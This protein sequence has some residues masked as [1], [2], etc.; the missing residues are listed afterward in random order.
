MFARSI[1]LA[2][3]AGSLAFATPALAQ[4]N[5]ETTTTTVSRSSD[6]ARF[7]PQPTGISTTIDY[8]FL[9]EALQYMV[10][11][12]GP[13]TRQ[14]MGKPAPGMGTRR[15]YGH[16]SR[17]RL[18]GNRIVFSFLDEDAIAPLTE[19]RKELEQLGTDLP[20]SS[21]PESEQLAYWMNLHNVS[22][23]EQIALNYPLQSPSR[24]KLGAG[25]TPLD[26]TPFITVD[27]VA[28]SPKDI[29]TKIVFPNW[30]DANVIY[31]FFRGEIGG[32]SIQRRAFNGQNL[33]E[34][35]GISATEFV[36]SLRGVEGFGRTL[37]V[38]A[39][40]EEAAP[41]YFP[42]MG[43]DL[44]AHLNR[45]AGEEVK[46]LVARKDSIEINQYED[47]VADL[48]A[49]DREPSYSYIEQDGIAQRTRISP[50]V[51]RLLGERYEKYEKLRREGL[52]RGRVIVLPP[53]T[54]E[55]AQELEETAEPE[56]EPQGI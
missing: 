48:A 54:S 25:R 21:L 20:I 55:R 10:L 26:E 51:A 16:E 46:A 24:M 15:L 49:G 5:V 56:T 9:D 52:L 28:M 22:V 40:Y 43:D 33:E 44:K 37:L 36:N 17:V 53:T 39:I 8:S 31:G 2:A 6:F 32:P 7:E 11:R 27:G 23:I 18:E 47:T 41:Y 29:R 1:A 13:S 12:M 50:S 4:E 42:Q 3:V 38:S 35:L 30:D 45:N 34:L 19:Y 14:G